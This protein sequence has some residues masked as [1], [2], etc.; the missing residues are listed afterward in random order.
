[1]KNLTQK[2][3]KLLLASSLFVI[4]SLIPQ[5]HASTGGTLQ[6]SMTVGYSCDI[7]IPSTSTLTPSGTTSTGS[8]LLPY[9]QNADTNYTLSA[10][11]ISGPTESDLTG[12]ISVRDGSSNTIVTNTSTTGSNSGQVIGNTG[13]T[14]SVL[15][16]VSENSESAFLAGSYT[17]S[18]VITCSQV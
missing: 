8:S 18:A 9:T 6:G 4:G 3:K 5:A 15:Y 13:G 12:S 14:G 17:I 10:V 7:T 2:M 16:T 11:T 1:M